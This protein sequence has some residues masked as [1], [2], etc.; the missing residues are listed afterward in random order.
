M[1]FIFLIT[2]SD[3]AHISAREYIERPVEGDML[4]IAFVLSG[5]GF[6][7][8]AIGYTLICEKL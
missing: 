1:N 2:S 6:F 5:L 3:L 4:D 7:G 8:I